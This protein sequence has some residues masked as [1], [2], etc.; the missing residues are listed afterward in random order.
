MCTQSIVCIYTCMA[1]CTACMSVCTASMSVCIASMSVCTACM[2][3][4]LWLYH[5]CACMA[6]S[7]M[8]KRGCIQ[9]ADV[10]TYL[11]QCDYMSYHLD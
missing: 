10:R 7:H 1:V 11:I 2:A 9:N 6:V 3:V 4:S 8:C 5:L